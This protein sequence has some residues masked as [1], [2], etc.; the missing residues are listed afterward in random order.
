MSKINIDTSPS[1]TV[2]D[3]QRI[4]VKKVFSPANFAT[5]FFLI[6]LICVGTYLLATNQTSTPSV[7]ISSGNFGCAGAPNTLPVLVLGSRGKCVEYA[8]SML[9]QVIKTS[10]KVSGTFD[11]STYS[12][13]VTFQKQYKLFVDGKIG[14]QTWSTLYAVY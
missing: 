11:S 7:A 8:Q 6:L 13:V 4:A 14:P 9:N 12:A 3:D 10:L 1:P 2:P 5:L